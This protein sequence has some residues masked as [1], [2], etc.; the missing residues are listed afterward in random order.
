M[1][2]ESKDE[3]IKVGFDSDETQALIRKSD[4]ETS[5]NHAI[6]LRSFLQGLEQENQDITQLDIACHAVAANAEKDAAGDVA[7]R[8]YSVDSSPCVFVQSATPRKIGTSKPAGFED[9]GSLIKSLPQGEL[10]MMQR[11]VMAA[12][13]PGWSMNPEKPGVVPTDDVMIAAGTI[14]ELIGGSK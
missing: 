5:G 6:S 1:L 9:G 14:A 3:V 2:D 8:T 10:A 11:W 7:G 4:N 13:E 12:T